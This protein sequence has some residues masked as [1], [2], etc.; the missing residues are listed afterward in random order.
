MRPHSTIH[1][2]IDLSKHAKG[3][4]DRLFPPQAQH[5]E[6]VWTNK[7]EVCSVKYESKNKALPSVK[8]P[9]QH[10]HTQTH[11]HLSFNQHPPPHRPMTQSFSRDPSPSP[12]PT[13]NHKHGVGREGVE[14]EVRP[15]QRWVVALSDSQHRQS[16]WMCVCTCAEISS[17]IYP[18]SSASSVFLRPQ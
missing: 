1:S 2:S 17:N 12:L 18:Q 4:T 16:W 14:L 3:R 9:T 11:T 7:Q 5:M 6:Q 10:K 8:P 13:V 15:G